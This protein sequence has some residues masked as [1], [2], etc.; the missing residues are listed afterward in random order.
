MHPEPETRFYL[1][2][3]RVGP[4]GRLAAFL[5][6]YL[7]GRRVVPHAQLVP[8]GISGAEADRIF[9]DEMQESQWTAAVVAERAAGLRVKVPQSAV[10]ILSVAP[11]SAVRSLAA[12]DVIRG[13]GSH[14][15]HAASD[16][17]RF[18]ASVPVGVPFPL[19]IRRDGVNR[20]IA[21]RTTARPGGPAIGIIV[22][23]RVTD[24]PELAVPVTYAI[25][26]I[27]GSSGGLLF[28]L[29]IYASL[30]P[31][32]PIAARIA[33]TGSL[34]YDGTVLPIEGAPQK[35]IAARRAGIRVFIV[36]RADYGEVAGT[37]EMRIIPVDRFSDAV[38]AVGL[39][40]PLR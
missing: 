12:G 24:A 10:R 8:L 5:A 6:R 31:G 30:R 36:P 32:R 17:R 25:P 4:A 35:V 15:V 20:T 34:A 2:D 3:V 9:A 26:H 39:P 7:P 40:P 1:T 37:P 14:A 38:R 13:V 11:W 29:R 23:T 28:A 33:G 21:A 16:V 18:A 27:S 22:G 19:L